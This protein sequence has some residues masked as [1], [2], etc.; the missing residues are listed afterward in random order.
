MYEEWT[1]ERKQGKYFF[2][3]YIKKETLPD[4]EAE[5]IPAQFPIP[6]SIH[7]PLLKLLTGTL[8]QITLHRILCGFSK[9]NGNK[10]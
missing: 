1:K 3:P 8:Y 6:Y 7:P 9:K 2:R 10:I 5:A 4:T